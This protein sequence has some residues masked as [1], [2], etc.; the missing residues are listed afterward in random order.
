M[1]MNAAAALGL[2]QTYAVNG[3]G[4]DVNMAVSGWL[5]LCA[6][7]RSSRGRLDRTSAR[8]RGGDNTEIGR[9]RFRRWHVFYRYEY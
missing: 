6:R 9:G 3:S 8:N 7:P 4:L 1:L 2:S 5:R